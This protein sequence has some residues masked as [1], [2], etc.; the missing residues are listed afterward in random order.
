MKQLFAL[1][2]FLIAAAPAF[3]QKVEAKP[4]SGNSSPNDAAAREATEKLVTKYALNADQAKE[5]YN[6]QQ[7][8]LRNMNEI[9]PLETSNRKQYLSKLESLQR[10]TLASIRRILRSKEQV[11]L[12][13]KTQS[14]VRTQ[15]AEKRKE[16]AGKNLPKEDVQAALLEIYAE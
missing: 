6:I 15:R 8:K 11:D 2:F 13:Q 16:L 14:E 3:S 7:R 1:A 10:G 9:A 12:Y 4:P 5:M